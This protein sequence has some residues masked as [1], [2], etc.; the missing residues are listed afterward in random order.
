MVI[1]LLVSALNLVP[2]YAIIPEPAL[3]QKP[4]FKPL[5][6]HALDLGVKELNKLFYKHA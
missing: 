5:D 2:S 6:M 1:L 4:L 3:E